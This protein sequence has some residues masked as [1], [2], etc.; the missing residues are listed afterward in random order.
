MLS[1][2]FVRHVSVI[3]IDATHFLIGFRFPGSPI[4][5]KNKKAV[6]YD[7]VT[8]H[9]YDETGFTCYTNWLVSHIYRNPL[10]RQ[11]KINTESFASYQDVFQFEVSVDNALF[12]NVGQS[13]S[14]LFHP[15]TNFLEGFWTL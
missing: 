11:V 8:S 10:F 5:R 9:A 6:F 13:I 7:H 1:G 15:L 2:R 14:D 12:M 4:M 3:D